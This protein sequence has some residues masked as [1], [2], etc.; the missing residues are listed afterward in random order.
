[1]TGPAVETET[2]KDLPPADAD[3]KQA[4]S[5]PVPAL[6]PALR[7]YQKLVEARKHITEV[8]KRGRH[9]S[10]GFNFATHDDITEV[11]KNALDHAGIAFIPF[12]VRREDQQRKTIAFVTYKLCC[13]E[14]GYVETIEDW[15]GE[16]QDNQ[17]KAFYKALTQSKK[18]FLLNLL[19][20]PTGD[21][22]ADGDYGHGYDEK[23]GGNSKSRSDRSEPRGPS[24]ERNNSKRQ[25]RQEDPSNQ[26][27]PPNQEPTQQAQP[28]QWGD[29]TPEK[30]KHIAIKRKELCDSIEWGPKYPNGYDDWIK[31]SGILGVDQE[32]GL[33][34]LAA[35]TVQQVSKLMQFLKVQAEKRPKTQ[36]AATEATE[37]KEAPAQATEGKAQAAPHDDLVVRI[38]QLEIQQSCQ[39]TYE[40]RIPWLKQEVAAAKYCL[41]QEDKPAE[42]LGP[43]GEDGTPLFEQ[44][45]EEQLRNWLGWLE[46]TPDEKVPF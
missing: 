15:P 36:A 21:R 5:K 1:M 8:P 26:A 33:P 7:F 13:T 11:C 38:E 45:S 35:S 27:P 28:T 41:I 40:A 4:E 10:F 24:S 39:E 20:V 9:E 44:W 14:T 16:G 42:F 18:T 17:D 23:K 37:A 30:R 29:L 46:R 31:A 6:E 34:S 43:V 19:M 32:T 12:R 25:S 3:P 2:E 22:L